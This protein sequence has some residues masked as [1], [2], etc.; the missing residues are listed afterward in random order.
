MTI[1]KQFGLVL[2][3]C[4]TFLLASPTIFAQELPT[5]LPDG[6]TEKMEALGLAAIPTC[7][8]EGPEEMAAQSVEKEVLARPCQGPGNQVH[9]SSVQAGPLS[10]ACFPRF[11]C[12]PVANSPAADRPVWLQK[13]E[14]H[15]TFFSSGGFLYEPP[16]MTTTWA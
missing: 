7:R 3:I 6:A 1:R 14:H 11:G 12:V 4:A 5:S 2:G 16:S 8:L 13:T 9:L 15:E 10:L